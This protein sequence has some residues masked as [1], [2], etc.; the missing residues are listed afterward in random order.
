MNTNCAK[1]FGSSLGQ[2]QACS[3]GKIY[4]IVPIFRNKAT[5]RVQEPSNEQLMQQYRD[6]D[7]NAFTQLY[8]RNKNTLYRY[9]LRQI[10]RSALA[11]ELCQDVWTSIVRSRQRYQQ[12][13]KFTTFLFQIAHNRL[14]DHFRHGQNRPV[15]PPAHTDGQ[16]EPHSGAN[17]NPQRRAESS[18]ATE[19]L[20]QLLATLPEQQKEVFILK[21]EAGLSLE[22]IASITGVSMETAKSRLRY[23]VAKLKQGLQEFL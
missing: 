14:V 11:E 19:K 21:E 15:D 5:D 3:V 1:F 16:D 18:Q 12:S 4:V 13:A 22:Q 9:F 23:A 7:L 17:Q 8:H 20:L 6:G 2:Q 10:R